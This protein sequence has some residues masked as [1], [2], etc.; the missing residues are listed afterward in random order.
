MKS[1]PDCLR[2]WNSSF[3][4]YILHIYSVIRVTESV[5]CFMQ[6]F[7]RSGEVNSILNHPAVLR[8]RSHVNMKYEQYWYL[9]SC[10][11]SQTFLAWCIAVYYNVFSDHYSDLFQT[12]MSP[13]SSWGMRCKSATSHD[14]I[15]MMIMMIMNAD[16]KIFCP[17]THCHIQQSSLSVH[18]NCA[19]TRDFFQF[20]RLLTWTGI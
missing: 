15:M 11:G 14:F 18:T 12:N 7:S 5:T 20:S 17:K 1:A 4:R 9:T 19:S 13:P 10:S 6:W 16:K 2:V 3:L 8:G